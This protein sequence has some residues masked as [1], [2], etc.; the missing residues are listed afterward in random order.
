MHGLAAIP[1]FTWKVKG[2]DMS[3]L[4]DPKMLPAAI[5]NARILRFGY[6]SIWYGKNPVRTSVAEAAKVLLTEM[7]YKRKV[8]PCFAQIMRN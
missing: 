8:Q 6:N 3:W 2:A 4:E 1:A 5:P 7:K